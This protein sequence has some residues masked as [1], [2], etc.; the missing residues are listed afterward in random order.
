MSG[1]TYAILEV[2]VF[3]VI[4]TAI[5]VAIGWV[6][7]RPAAT[8]MRGVGD[9]R[10]VSQLEA[11]N[12]ILEGRLADSTEQ[13]ERALARTE[14]LRQELEQARGPRLDPPASS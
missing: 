12:L 1:T 14:E 7:K 9:D 2:L 3:L 4:A 5:G 6:L 11:R 13:L 8:P 10:Q